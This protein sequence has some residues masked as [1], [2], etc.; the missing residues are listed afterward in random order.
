MSSLIRCFKKHEIPI[1][2]SSLLEKSIVSLTGFEEFYNIIYLM[3]LTL[4]YVRLI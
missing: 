4:S 3:D 2:K 1:R